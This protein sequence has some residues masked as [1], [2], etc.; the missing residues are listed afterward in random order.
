MTTIVAIIGLVLIVMLIVVM[1]AFSIKL[2]D[3][4]D[5]MLQSE[6]TVNRIAEKFDGVDDIQIERKWREEER[7]NGRWN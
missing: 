3:M 6:D 4:R 1:L 5:I 2:R 7:R